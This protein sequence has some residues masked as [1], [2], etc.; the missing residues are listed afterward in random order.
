M[1][2]DPFTGL[3]LTGPAP[4]PKLDQRLFAPR[5]SKAV[6]P[7]IPPAKVQQQSA[8]VTPAESAPAKAATVR[9]TLES[10]TRDFDLDEKPFHKHSYLL[11]QGELE[12]IQDLQ[13][14]L[15]R[16]L[17]A[18]VTKNDLVRCA[19]HMLI[20]DYAKDEKRSY[21]RNKIETRD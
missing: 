6:E 2:Q 11:T 16:E 9:V 1:S 5:S 4:A 15:S 12:A 10:L 14:E 18:K 20:E 17:D 13:I 21:A 19:L 3:K 7:S 8:P